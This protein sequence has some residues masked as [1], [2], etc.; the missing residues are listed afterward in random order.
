MFKQNSK[1]KSVTEETPKIFSKTFDRTCEINIRTR[2]F[3]MNR[4]SVERESRKDYLKKIFFQACNR[5]QVAQAG[6]LYNQM[7]KEPMLAVEA[8]IF[9]RL[10]SFKLKTEL[11]L[12]EFLKV[13][14]QIKE[15][16]INSIRDSFS[17]KER[18]KSKIDSP[19]ENKA[20]KAVIL[21]IFENY[22]LNGDGVLSVSELKNG[23]KDFLSPETAKELFKEFDLD[24][25][26]T[27]DRKEFLKLF[28]CK[29]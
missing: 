5:M 24:Q 21:K 16:R 22:D 18:R 15:K 6:N 23:M 1:K 27:L 17:V 25:S 28:D 2:R 8:E 14:K 11:N 26:N 10:F 19:Q 12:P 4:S 7:T 20:K 9:F 3:S 13:C 29:K